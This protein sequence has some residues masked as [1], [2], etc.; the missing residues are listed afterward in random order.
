M[1]VFFGIWLSYRRGLYVVCSTIIGNARA[2]TRG[3]DNRRFHAF[4]CSVYFAIKHIKI[5]MNALLNAHTTRDYESHQDI[6][7]TS[8]VSPETSNTNVRVSSEYAY[9]EG[10]DWYVLRITYNRVKLAYDKAV[11][12]GI[13]AYVPMHYILKVI[14]GKKTRMLKP[15]LFNILFIYATKEQA[16]SLVRK[17]GDTSSY[18]K[19]YLDKTAPFDMNGKNPPLIIPYDDMINFIMATS[20]NSEH[21]RIVTHAQCHYKSGN[22]VRVTDGDFKGIVGKVARIAGQQRVV[23]NIY[24]LCM[25]ATAYIPSDF[26]EIIK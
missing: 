10:H 13:K 24:G 8:N 19:F 22:L 16:H 4:L 7:P 15:L 6:G 2:S 26:I 25:V 18:I 14:D 17:S 11:K 20:T 5:D 1:S 21:V 3:M 12:N 23:V 9:K